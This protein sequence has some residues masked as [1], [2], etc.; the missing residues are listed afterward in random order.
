MSAPATSHDFTDEERREQVAAF[1]EVQRQRAIDAQEREHIERE[2]T[3]E[4][5][6]VFLAEHHV[7][8]LLTDIR[9]ELRA[10][11]GGSG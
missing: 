6:L 4:R 11:R 10:A 8:P 7:I 5:R 3:P 2:S 9:D 1:R